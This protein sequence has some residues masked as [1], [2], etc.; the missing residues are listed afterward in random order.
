VIVTI[1]I[2][3]CFGLATF[4]FLAAKAFP[5]D[6]EGQ[7]IGRSPHDRALA[8]APEGRRRLRTLFEVRRRALAVRLR[9]L[10]LG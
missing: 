6:Y 5:K 8:V 9:E 3:T 4:A 7:S 1:I 10:G 2:L